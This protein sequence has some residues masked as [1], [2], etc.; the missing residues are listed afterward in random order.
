MS[1]EVRPETL[2]EGGIWKVTRSDVPNIFV[3]AVAVVVPDGPLPRVAG[4]NVT[5]TLARGIVPLGKPEPITP[6]AVTA[7]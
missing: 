4:S 2:I 7:A 5:V 6:T 3:T 1:M